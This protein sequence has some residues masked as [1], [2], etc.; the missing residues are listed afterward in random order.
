[1]D[2]TATVTGVAE[3]GGALDRYLGYLAVVWE[4]LTSPAGKAILTSLLVTQLVKTFDSLVW[5]D[6]NPKQVMALSWLIGAVAYMLL[7]GHPW[8]DHFWEG[9]A[10]G[11]VAPALV[12]AL[13]WGAGK[14]GLTWMDPDTWLAGEE[15]P[16]T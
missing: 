10:A 8:R 14:T 6:L 1:M 4:Y 9:L 11:L 13:K 12:A 7:A 3:V 16:K 2:L 15:P 5:R